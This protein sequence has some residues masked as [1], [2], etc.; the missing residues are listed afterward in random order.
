[1]SLH[2]A[3]KNSDCVVND[4][5]VWVQEKYV[6]P[7]RVPE[8]DVITSSVSNVVIA[9]NDFHEFD[10]GY[11]LQCIV[12]AVRVDY[13]NFR[14]RPRAAYRVPNGSRCDRCRSNDR[15]DASN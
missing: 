5:G 8:S 15:F 4:L 9:G 1:M 10:F 11:S 7:D 14:E 6:L 3:P 13:D 12:R 2:Q